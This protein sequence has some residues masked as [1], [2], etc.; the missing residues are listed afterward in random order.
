[1]SDFRPIALR[2]AEFYYANPLVRIGIS[3]LIYD[4]FSIYTHFSETHL[5]RV[6]DQIDE[7]DLEDLGRDY[8]TKQ[9][10]VYQGLTRDG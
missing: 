5:G 1:M 2:Q 9:Q 8:Y 10:Q 6:M 4:F 3:F 7:D